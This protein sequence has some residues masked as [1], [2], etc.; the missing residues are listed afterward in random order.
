[1]TM[2]FAGYPP[3][4]DNQNSINGWMMFDDSLFYVFE[5]INSACTSSASCPRVADKPNTMNC[6][7]RVQNLFNCE[8]SMFGL[9]RVIHQWW[10]T[11]SIWIDTIPMDDV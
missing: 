10:R 7:G 3:I 2:S 8:L 4:V 1:V 6:L 9:V 5:D 11:R